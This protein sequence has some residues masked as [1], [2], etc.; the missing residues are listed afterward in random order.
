M[1]CPRCGHAEV[2]AISAATTDNR[3]RCQRCEH[4]FAA[5][6]WVMRFWYDDDAEEA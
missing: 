1:T 6:R 5:Y 4:V 2:A 3:V